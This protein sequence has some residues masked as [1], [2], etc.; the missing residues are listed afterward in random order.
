MDKLYKTIDKE[1]IQAREA[2]LKSKQENKKALGKLFGM[3]L[4]LEDN[5]STKG[6]LT[7]AGSKMLENYIAPFDAF[8]VEKILEEDGLITGKIDTREFG[9]GREIDSNMGRVINEGGADISIG[10]DVC[11]EM[12]NIASASGLY[13]LKATYGSISRYGLIGSGPSL[14]Q[15]GIISK[16]IENMKKVFYTIA[17]KDVRD[18]TSFEKREIKAKD[19]K[20]IKIGIIKDEM[21]NLDESIREEIDKS[22]KIFKELHFTVKMTSIPSAKYAGTV[23]NILQSAEFSSDMGKFDGVAYGYKTK[24]YSDNEDFFKKNRSL[25][26]S[27]EVKKKIM[28]GNFLLGKDNYKDYYEKS[29]KIRTLMTK[30]L[31][32]KFQEYD[33]I[34]SPIVEEDSDYTVLANIAGKPAISLPSISKG[35]KLGLQIMGDSFSEEVLFK[36]A[37]VYE[38]EVLKSKKEVK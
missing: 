31:D 2:F 23:F 26:F 38:E 1:K 4:A 22:L 5:I 11:G 15:V 19:I 27:E 14:E 37:Q 10:I 24:E 18:S 33:I 8:V 30:E 28:F 35:K 17:G 12:R 7:S 36:L 25:G 13:A 21:E 16:N 9:V 3:R 29:Q 20:K 6:M 32:E 34:L